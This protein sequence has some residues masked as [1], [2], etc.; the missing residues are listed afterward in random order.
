MIIEYNAHCLDK[1]CFVE[2]CR[3]EIT[4]YCKQCD[5]IFF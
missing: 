3:S 2:N 1:N 5:C 4:I